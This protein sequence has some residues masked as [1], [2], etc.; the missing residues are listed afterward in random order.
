MD[1]YASVKRGRQEICCKA[2]LLPIAAV[3]TLFLA[4]CA[5]QIH[6]PTVSHEPAMQDDPWLVR[7]ETARVHDDAPGNVP[8][9]GNLEW[10][11][12]EDERGHRIEIDGKL[13]D[14]SGQVIHE[15]ASGI[16]TPRV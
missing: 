12:A 4:S 15:S 11:F 5:M 2:P 6:A 14:I 13:V 3:C 16:S 1:K 9:A 7:C 10:V 8:G